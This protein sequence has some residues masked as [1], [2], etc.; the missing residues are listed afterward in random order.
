[1][2]KKRGSTKSRHPYA[3]QKRPSPNKTAKAYTAG[4]IDGEGSISLVLITTR[5]TKSGRPA[6]APKLV[7]QVGN[8]N[9]KLIQWL[10]KTW[11]MG[12]VAGPYYVKNPNAK[13]HYCWR[14]RGPVAAKLLHQL[15][16]YLVIKRQQAELGL[17]AAALAK[18]NR[19]IGD[20]E[21]AERLKMREEMLLLN[22]R[23]VS[24]PRET[25]RSARVWLK[26]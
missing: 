10:V 14:V 21:M 7:I 22:Q 16:P 26:P 18:S 20:K 25:S 15:L 19:K 3:T 11:Q 5:R 2:T 6:T 24:P 9:I 13:P 4:I 17:R 1:M 8:T 12:S 23:G